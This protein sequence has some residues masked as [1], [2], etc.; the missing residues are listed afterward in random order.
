[1]PK[2]TTCKMNDRAIDIVEALAIRDRKPNV[3]FHCRECGEPVRAHEKGT[4]GQA[5]HFEHM[6]ANP[7][8]R[9]SSDR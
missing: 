7:H 3:E 2:A 9:L 5:A 1:M 8:C 6:T 4:T